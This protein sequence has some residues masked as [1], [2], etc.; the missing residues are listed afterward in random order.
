MNILQN[1]KKFDRIVKKSSDIFFIKLATYDILEFKH[2]LSKNS[3]SFKQ[4]I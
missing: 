1:R 4:T 2:S 3:F